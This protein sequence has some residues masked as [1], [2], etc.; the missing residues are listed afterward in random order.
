[1]SSK[2]RSNLIEAYEILRAV[3]DERFAPGLN[4]F[5]EDENGNDIIH[6]FD[7][8]PTINEFKVGCGTLACAAGWIML[9]ERFRT[10]L[11]KLYF[12]LGGSLG[13]DDWDSWAE[14]HFGEPLR[15]EYR[16]T[17]DRLFSPEGLSTYDI[18]LAG[19]RRLDFTDKMLA[20]YRIR[21]ELGDEPPQALKHVKEDCRQ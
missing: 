11:S 6:I 3:P 14:K 21:R 15:S 9:D 8:V 7:R 20:M 4:Q 16:G 12:A 19:E 2:R 1:M 18:E 5:V 17:F 13:E 10:D